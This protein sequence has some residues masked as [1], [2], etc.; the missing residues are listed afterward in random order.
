MDSPCW[1]FE[2]CRSEDGYGGISIGGHCGKMMRA[3]RAAWLV[4]HGDIPAGIFVCHKCDHPPCCRPDHLFLGTQSDNMLDAAAKGRLSVSRLVSRN[5][6]ELNG[7][8]ILTWDQAGRIR[9]RYAAGEWAA[10]LAS[11]FGVSR[12]TIYAL[13]QGRTWKAA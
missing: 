1:I 5:L 9:D 3:H 10:A 4:T 12:E 6:G 13:G 2:G 7:R 8:A 11:E